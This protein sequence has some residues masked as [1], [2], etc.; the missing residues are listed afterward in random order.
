MKSKASDSFCYRK[1]A[2]VTSLVHKH[3]FRKLQSFHRFSRG[4]FQTSYKTKANLN[5]AIII[6]NSNR[7]KIHYFFNG[8]IISY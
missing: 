4:I 8:W 3:Y 7:V 2:Q 1:V 6:E 5:L